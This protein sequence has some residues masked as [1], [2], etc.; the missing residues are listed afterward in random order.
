[1]FWFMRVIVW[2]PRYALNFGP[3]VMSYEQDLFMGQK[4]LY[5]LRSYTM[6][7][8]NICRWNLRWSRF[9]KIWYCWLLNHRTQLACND[10]LQGRNLKLRVCNLYRRELA[11]TWQSLLHRTS[12]S[13][14]TYQSLWANVWT[15]HLSNIGLVKKY[16]KKMLL[17]KNKNA[18]SKCILPH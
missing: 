18:P 13:V 2:Q 9:V 10:H 5:W 14:G 11:G 1:M 4:V 17:N 15:R 6:G 7:W 12:K 3:Q 16:L 8:N